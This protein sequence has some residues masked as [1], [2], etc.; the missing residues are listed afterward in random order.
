MT[1][2]GS[3]YSLNRKVISSGVAHVA[4]VFLWVS[5]MAFHGAYFSNYASWLRDPTHIKPSAQFVWGCVGQDILNSDVGGYFQGIYTTSGLFQMWRAQGILSLYQLK[6]V[7]LVSLLGA[8]ALIGIAYYIMHICPIKTTSN[9]LTYR[10]MILLAGLASISWSA[11][12]IHISAPINRL[13]EVGVEPGLIL[14]PQDFLSR[15]IIRSVFPGFGQSPHALLP[16]NATDNTTVVSMLINGYTDSSGALP[17]A[18]VASHHLFLGI[19]LILG[20]LLI[21]N[22][23][24]EARS[25]LLDSSRTALL[26]WHT[27]LSL[28]MLLF[29]SMS[30]I[31]SHNVYS[32]PVYPYL[33]CDYA[34]LLSLYCHHMWIGGF[35]MVGYG[36]HSSL[37]LLLDLTPAANLGLVY[38]IISHRDIIIGH[39][40]WVVLFLGMHSFGLYIHNDT[41]Q[42][43]GRPE[44]TFSDSSLQ[45]KPIFSTLAGYSLSS[46]DI[47]YSSIQTVGSKI[48][49]VKCCL[50]TSEFMLYH[51]HAF[52]IHTTALV[53]LKGSLYSRSSRLVSDK[54][55][56]GFMYPCDGPG[57]GGTCQIS[58]WDHVFLSLFWMYNSI[59]ILIFHFSWKMQSDV[60]GSLSNDATSTKVSHLTSGDFASNSNSINGW[61]RTFLWSQSAQVIQSY[62]TSLSAYSLPFLGAHLIWAFDLMLLFSGRGYWQELIESIIWSHQKMKLIPQVQPRALS[63]TQGRSVG[64]SHYILGGLE[65]KADLLLR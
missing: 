53:L 60:W 33:T 16:F 36:A 39:L 22:R 5:G 44:D 23:S 3:S 51:I 55:G 32:L 49:Y 31:Q 15:D 47:S 65:V 48:T 29:A 59:S 21:R 12:L 7:S 37:A 57:R 35:F 8:L 4:I 58:P 56:L 18:V 1:E 34:T 38:R 27:Q 25:T 42:A 24:S 43:L 50:G 63:I 26:S 17:A 41:L 10:T 46:S 9:L 2:S 61:L 30:F 11:H 28:A 6:L 13:L 62:S 45:L 54:H 40:I 52:T 14:A 64:V 20:G 19:S